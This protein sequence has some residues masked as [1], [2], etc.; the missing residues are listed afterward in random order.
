LLC[1]LILLQSCSLKKLIPDNKLLLQKVTVKKAPREYR[2]N[3]KLLIIQK[4]RNKGIFFSEP[5]LWLYLKMDKGKKRGIKETLKKMFGEKPIYLDTSLTIE[6]K[7]RLNDYLINNGYFDASVKIKSKIQHKKQVKL[8]YILTL[9]DPY[10]ISEISYIVHDSNIKKLIDRDISKTLIEKG[11]KY[12]SDNLL[13]EIVRVTSTLNDHGYYKFNKNFI[14]YEVDTSTYR[15]QHQVSVK[16][17]IQNYSDTSLHKVY[18][19]KNIFLEPDYKLTDQLKKDTTLLKEFTYVTQTKILKPNIFNRQ[20]R[21]A[22]GELYSFENVKQTI[23]LLTDVQFFKYIDISFTESELYKSDTNYLDC[24]IKLTPMKKLETSFEIEVNTTAE[25]KDISNTSDRYYGMAGSI[26]FRNRNLFKRAIQF[27]AGILGAFDLQ[28]K[29]IAKQVLF[30]NYQVGVNTALYFP[31]AYIPKSI[32]NSKRYQSSKTAINLSYFYEYNS[33]FTRTTTNLAYVYQL[34]KRFTRHFITPLEL[35]LVKTIK[36]PR[37]AQTL[38]SL[39]D[40]LL[41]NIFEPHILTILKYSTVY[42][43]K[44]RRERHYLAVFFGIETAGNTS[45]LFNNLTSKSTFSDST[46]YTFGG[47]DFFQYIKGDLDI[48]YHHNLNAGTSIAGRLCLGLGVPYGNSDQLPFEKRYFIGGANSIR[49]WPMRELGPGSYN[50]TT[51]LHFEQS[52]EIKIEGNIEYRFNIYSLLKGAFFL[53][54]GNIWN[55]KKNDQRIGSEFNIDRFYKEIALGTGFGLRFDFTYF[56]FRLDFGIPLHDPSIVLDPQR[57]V[58]SK[59]LTSH[60]FDDQW[61]WNNTLINIGIG[62]PF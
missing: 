16:M 33:D 14:Y 38:D 15:K 56:I 58:N 22:Q 54:A 57:G 53:D 48:S 10:Y 59:W 13:N 3:M 26:N 30:G 47:L 1:F 43:D 8:K 39:N 35:S 24:Y 21:F 9:K 31:T 2:A 11:Q 23:N 4:P 25:K 45:W 61:L 27:S 36:Q 40:P 5:Y 41:N 29:S 19:I 51:N 37:F 42:N 50:D 17:F 52:G 34:N 20:I 28:S 62:Y 46:R 49:A 6:T 7:T 12:S 60:W 18:F 55:L 44:G 32:F